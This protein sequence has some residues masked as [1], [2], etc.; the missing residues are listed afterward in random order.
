M[1]SHHLHLGEGEGGVN[2]LLLGSKHERG[3]QLTGIGAEG[4]D[5]KGEVEG[6]V[7]GGDGGGG[8]VQIVLTELWT[9]HNNCSTRTYYRLNAMVFRNG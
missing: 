5:D 1:Q 9:I 3:N 4:S 8:G 7:C 6:C 2:F